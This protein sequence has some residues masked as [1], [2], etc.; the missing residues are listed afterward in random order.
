MGGRC[1]SSLESGY[2][3]HPALPPNQTL[4]PAEV[5]FFFLMGASDE[6]VVRK[7]G[8]WAGAVCYDARREMIAGRGI[9]KAL[10]GCRKEDRASDP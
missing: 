9:S 2:L 7:K 4:G 8:P 3:T 5:Y 6:E 10:P 1:L